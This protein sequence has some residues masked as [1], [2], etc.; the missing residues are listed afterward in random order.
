MNEAAQAYLKGEGSFE[1]TYLKKYFEVGTLMN[2][3]RDELQRIWDKNYAGREKILRTAKERNLKVFHVDY[4]S[5]ESNGFVRL[6]DDSSV[7]WNY[8][9][10]HEIMTRNIY[11]HRN[12]CDDSM[13]L[14]GESHVDTARILSLLESED[15]QTR[16]CFDYS[17]PELRSL[18]NYLQEAG[19]TTNAVNVVIDRS[20]TRQFVVSDTA[21]L[22]AERQSALRDQELARSNNNYLLRHIPA[23]ISTAYDQVYIYNGTVD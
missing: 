10:R 2:F 4:T 3:S 8:A 15:P 23:N 13:Y 12:E 6:T 9:R 1:E 22:S 18:E 19:F 7:I 16:E 5:L 17:G 21:S 20:E 11:S 14:L